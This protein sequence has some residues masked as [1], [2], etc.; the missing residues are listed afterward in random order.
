MQLMKT[1]IFANWPASYSQITLEDNETGH[2]YTYAQH[3]HFPGP[4]PTTA[5]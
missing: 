2:G 1:R 5:C 3:C 4:P